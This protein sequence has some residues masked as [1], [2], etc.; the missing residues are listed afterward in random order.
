[1]LLVKVE[2]RK[3]DIDG[4]GCFT[5]EPIQKGQLLWVFDP[6]IDTR[7]RVS[8]LNELPEAVQQ[9]VK[10]YG[11]QEVVEGEPVY[12]MCGDHSKFMNH[13][14]APNTMTD[15]E[16]PLVE[17]AARDIQTGEELTCNYFSF[18]SDAR[19]KLAAG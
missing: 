18:D 9:Y 11:F 14:D 13:A 6:R 1:M 19:Y 3:S 7:V 12:T 8:E 10:I 4:L 17:I 2:L 15:P 16:N 5:L